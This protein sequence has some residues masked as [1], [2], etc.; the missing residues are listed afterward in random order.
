MARHNSEADIV[1]IIGTIL[2]ISELIPYESYGVEKVRRTILLE[3]TEGERIEWCFY[4]SWAEWFNDIAKQI[5]T[6]RKVVMVLQVARVKYFNRNPSVSN[7]VYGTKLYINEN[8]LEIIAF[9]KREGILHGFENIS[10]SIMSKHL[11]LSILSPGCAN[12]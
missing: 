7:L 12:C 9:R 11:F 8:I 4:E 1:D 5:Q 2:E 3:D 6:L 10:P